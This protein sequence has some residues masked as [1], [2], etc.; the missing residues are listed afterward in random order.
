MNAEWPLGPGT[1]TAQR[2]VVQVRPLHVGRPDCPLPPQRRDPETAPDT[3]CSRERSRWRYSWGPLSGV[4]G[5]ERQYEPSGKTHFFGSPAHLPTMCPPGWVHPQNTRA[6]LLGG[7]PMTSNL[8]LKLPCPPGLTTSVAL[9]VVQEIS[10]GH[11]SSQPARPFRKTVSGTGGHC[12]HPP[13]ST[14]PCPWPL[15]PTPSSG[16]F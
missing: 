5:R 7:S 16:G 13:T 6:L 2:L 12:H 3:L 11:R 10:R 15:P 4:E 8:E 9:H 1:E 14:S